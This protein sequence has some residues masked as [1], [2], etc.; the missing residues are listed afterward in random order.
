M[1]ILLLFYSTYA[2]NL[3]HGSIPGLTNLL[4]SVTGSVPVP[5]SY[6]VITFA[7]LSSKLLHDHTVTLSTEK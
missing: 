3:S 5:I 4:I 6:T 7:Q 1:K 2:D